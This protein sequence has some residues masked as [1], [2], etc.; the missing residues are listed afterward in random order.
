MAEAPV[1]MSRPVMG[2]GGWFGGGAED[3]VGEGG[4]SCSVAALVSAAFR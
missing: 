3:G 1:P 2:R 4:T